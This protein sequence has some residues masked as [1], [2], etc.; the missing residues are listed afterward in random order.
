MRPNDVPAVLQRLREQNRRDGTSY[1]MPQVFDERGVRLPGIPLAL[2]AVDVDTGLVVQGHVWI[3]TL[4]Q[5][6]FGTNTQ[7]TVCS[8]HEHPAVFHLLRERGYRDL[9]ILVPVERVPE[10]KHGLDSILKT[11]DTGETL[12]HFYRLLDPAENDGL[13]NWY[14]ERGAKR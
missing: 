12:K 4:E 7:A 3:R 8:M 9:H 5:M 14:K 2:V 1:S 10:M 13:R 6:S 11:I